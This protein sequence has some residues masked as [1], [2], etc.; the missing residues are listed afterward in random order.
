MD[1][2]MGG[3]QQHLHVQDASFLNEAAEI[4]Q[5]TFSFWQRLHNVANSS[6]FWATAASA[7]GRGAQAHTPWGDDN[8]VYYDT[9]GCCAAGTQRIQGSRD[10]DYTQW[11]HFA[12]V[13]S[14]AVKQIFID[15][16]LLIDGTASS[17]LP[18]DFDQ[19]YIG[20]EPSLVN[21]LQGILDDFA[22]Y[23]SAL[24]EAQVDQLAAGVPPDEIGGGPPPP[25]DSFFI[26]S[27]ERTSTGSIL[28]TLPLGEG[29]NADAQ[30]SETMELD[31]WIDIGAF[32]LNGTTGTFEDTDP[33]RTGLDD[34]FYRAMRR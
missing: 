10:I 11:H 20:S 25:D 12:F 18:T 30:F 5:L 13:K 24:S 26:S 14:G 22:V 27:I 3:S 4:D 16:E 19:L 15:G 2:G 8:V 33:G 28:L 32:I 9:G 34:G 21:N 1:L 7:G 31:S 29:E 17:P 6:A 23:A